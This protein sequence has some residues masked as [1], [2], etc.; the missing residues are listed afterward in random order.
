MNE[1]DFSETGTRVVSGIWWGDTDTDFGFSAPD[2]ARFGIAWCLTT[3]SRAQKPDP[4]DWCCDWHESGQTFAKVAV[5]ESLHRV[6]TSHCVFSSPK[7]PC[8]DDP[9]NHRVTAGVLL[10]SREAGG[11]W[12][13][14]KEATGSTRIGIERLFQN[15]HTHDA[16]VV[17]ASDWLTRSMRCS[18]V[19]SDRVSRA[20]ERPDAIGWANGYS[21]LVECKA[22]RS[23]FLTDASKPHRAMASIGMGRSRYY[24]APPGLIGKHDLPPGWGLVEWSGS[25]VVVVEANPMGDWNEH[26]EVQH[27][28]A[29]VRRARR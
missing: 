26:A 15:Q 25:P 1:I 21:I 22:S 20:S 17:A 5:S 4:K 18:V 13:V 8:P 28:V 14:D 24:F 19:I 3:K 27:L 6:N 23:D 11:L 9:C 7:M 10:V 2:W 12:R 16:L 29:E